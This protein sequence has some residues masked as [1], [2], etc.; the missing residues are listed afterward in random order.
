MSAQWFITVMVKEVPM[1]EDL[2]RWLKED[3]ECDEVSVCV[4]G[5]NLYVSCVGE[6]LVVR[7]CCNI[8]IKSTELETIN[9]L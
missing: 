2:K 9:F 7:I 1:K 6:L 8:L 5:G 3:M 4:K